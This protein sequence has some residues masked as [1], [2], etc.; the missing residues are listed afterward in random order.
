MVTY[1]LQT[2]SGSSLRG[3]GWKIVG[4]VKPHDRWAEKSRRDG[5]SREWQPIYGQM[6]FRWEAVA[7]KG[8]SP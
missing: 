7:E 5:M 8:D 6:K 2:E 4:E 3:A 1:T